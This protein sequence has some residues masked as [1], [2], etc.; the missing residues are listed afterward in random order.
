MAIAITLKQFLADSGIDYEMLTHP[1]AV[2]SSKTAEV[3][4]IPGARLAKAVVLKDGKDGYLLAVL[5][6]SHH[7]QLD[8]LQGWLGRPVVLATEEEIEALFDDCDLGAVP[9][10]G[11]AYGLDVVMDESLGGDDDVYF[12]GG[13]HATLIRVAGTSFDK[14]MGNAHQGQFSRSP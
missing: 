2:S 12:E 10:I 4:H 3:S 11:N 7:I 9:P 1:R 5:P 8:A 13:D 14:L 6:A